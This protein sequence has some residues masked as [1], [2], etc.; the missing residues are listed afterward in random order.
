MGIVLW[1]SS[2]KA[3]GSD[4]R[5]VL[6]RKVC[7]AH[8]AYLSAVVGNRF[9]NH[10]VCPRVVGICRHDAHVAFLRN[11]YHFGTG[12][13]HVSADVGAFAIEIPVFDA[14]HIE[15]RLLGH[16]RQSHAEKKCE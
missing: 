9:G 2:R 4:A 14:V 5:V 6:E 16:S 1:K 13:G 3:Y 15:V 8:Y 11:G 12:P 10:Q 7:D